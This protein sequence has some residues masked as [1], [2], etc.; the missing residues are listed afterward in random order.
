[1]QEFE[2]KLEKISLQKLLFLFCEQQTAKSFH[3]V[4]YKFGCFSFQANADLHTLDKYGL[5]SESENFW[6]KLDTV[7]YFEGLRPP[8]RSVLRFIKAEYGQMN[9]DKLIEF[10]Y[11]NYPY[12]T[13]NSKIAG[14][15]LD[16]TEIKK[17]RKIKPAS[18]ENTLFTIGYEGLS[19]EEFLN[20]LIIHDIKVLCDVRKNPLSKKYGFSKNQLKKACEGVGI[21]YV[22]IP[23]VGIRSDKRRNLQTQSDYNKLFAFYRMDILPREQKKQKE[24]LQLLKDKKRIAITC[25]EANFNQCHRKHLAESISNM[26]GFAY[27]ISHI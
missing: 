6:E 12:Y 15:I 20:K 19:L 27:K 16:E 2:G 7:D 5:I 23:E 4:P 25:F 1:L 17:V 21:E 3:F 9:M 18:N 11:K 13:I 14:S 8:D 10:T 26:E 24:I 22:H